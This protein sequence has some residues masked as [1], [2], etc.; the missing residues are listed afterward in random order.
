MFRF[1]LRR[2]LLI[3]PKVLVALT[4]TF[5]MVQLAPGS[6]LSGGRRLPLEIEANLRQSMASTSPDS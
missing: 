1:V 4:V 6:P 3:I 5:V 2:L